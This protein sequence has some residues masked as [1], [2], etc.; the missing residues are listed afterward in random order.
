[1]GFFSNMLNTLRCPRCTSKD[2]EIT[3]GGTS[4]SGLKG[5]LGK[6]M[7][8]NTGLILGA[9]GRQNKSICHCRRCGLVWHKKL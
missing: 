4:Y 8:G 7:F 3:S 1:M 5:G 9:G 6:A 2:V